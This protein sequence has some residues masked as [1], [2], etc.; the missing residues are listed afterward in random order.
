MNWSVGARTRMPGRTSSNSG[1][2]SPKGPMDR[3]RAR[4][5]ANPDVAALLG[6]I[7]VSVHNGGREGEPTD[8]LAGCAGDERVWFVDFHD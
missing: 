6:G 7:A 8:P 5:G 1:R 3:L 2:T 4:A